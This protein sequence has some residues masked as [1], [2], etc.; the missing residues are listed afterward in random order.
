MKG[1]ANILTGQ[2]IELSLKHLK[3]SRITSF[4]FA[5][6]GTTPFLCPA[7]SM[8]N[9]F[10]RSGSSDE[11]INYKI[12]AVAP[13]NSTSNVGPTILK[14][15]GGQGLCRHGPVNVIIT[16]IPSPRQADMF[17]SVTVKGA[18]SVS[19]MYK[20]GSS[21]SSPY[22]VIIKLFTCKLQQGSNM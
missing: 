19:F 3:D 21:T 18:H 8:P 20:Y 7:G 11:N 2:H 22:T 6:P 13:D 15:S 16:S 1:P 10:D 14:P 5:I 17:V 4:L 9:T 12:E